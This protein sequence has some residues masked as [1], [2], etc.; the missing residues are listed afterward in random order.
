LVLRVA[1]YEDFGID[2]PRVNFAKIAE[3]AGIRDF[4]MESSSDLKG[5]D[6]STIPPRMEAKGVA[7]YGLYG[8][9]DVARKIV[10][11]H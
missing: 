7:G 10:R 1:G 5:P 3:A 4:R 9:T 2:I 6:A 11:V 8:E